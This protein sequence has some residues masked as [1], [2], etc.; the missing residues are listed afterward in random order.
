MVQVGGSTTTYTV[1]GLEK[2]TYYKFNVVAFDAAGNRLAKSVL[3]RAVTTGGEYTN[4]SKIVLET[5]QNLEMQIGDK[6]KVKANL[7]LADNTKNYYVNVAFGKEYILESSDKKVVKVK[8]GR[9]IAVGKGK[10]LV[11][12]YAQNGTHQII[13]VEVK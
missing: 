7:R 13:E 12:V 2:A 3:A 9:I 5:S 10:C 4:V 8:N 1:S 6:V 11:Y